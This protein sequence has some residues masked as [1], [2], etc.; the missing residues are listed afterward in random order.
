MNFKKQPIFSLLLL[1]FFLCLPA[2]G[3]DWTSTNI[4]A[5]YGNDFELGV[6]E[7]TTF[8]IEHAN[9]WKYGSNFF[10]VDVIDRNDVGIEVY[11]EAYTYLSLKKTTGYTIP[12]PG[13]NDISLFGGINISNKPEEDHFK[14]YIGGLSFDFSNSVFKLLQ[15][16]VAAYKADN[17]SGKYGF[18]ITPVWELPFEIGVAKFR[19]R[20][21]TDFRLGHTTDSGHFNV[22]AQPQLLLDVG[23]F[24]GF[25]DSVYIGAEY[26]LW[27]N[28]FGIKGVDESVVQGMIIAFF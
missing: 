20:G 24:A 13:L 23:H 2:Y 12:I 11:A 4:Q 9:G 21:F 17:V 8:T 28:K 27:H 19:F 16:D 3:F 15:I 7:R 6:D 25:S 1:Q 10:F 14:A 18:Q 5:L 26:S 22:L